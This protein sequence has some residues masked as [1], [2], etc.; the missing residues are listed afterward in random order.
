MASVDVDNKHRR[1]HA[2]RSVTGSKVYIK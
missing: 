2:G 1:R